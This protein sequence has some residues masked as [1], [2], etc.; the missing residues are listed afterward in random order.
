M[1]QDILGW[2]G[3][4]AEKDAAEDIINGTEDL[5]H[6]EYLYLRL[7]LENMIRPNIFLDRGILF[8]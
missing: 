4:C 5:S 3:T 7:L 1:H 2:V 8:T 6:I